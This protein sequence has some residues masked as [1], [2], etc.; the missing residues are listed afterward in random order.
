[1]LLYHLIW[2]F[3]MFYEYIIV[4]FLC[5]MS[6]LLFI[7]YVPGVYYCFNMVIIMMSIFL[8][9]MV[10]NVSRG[11]DER[12]YVPK[13][14]HMVKHHSYN[15]NQLPLT[16]CYV[17]GVVDFQSVCLHLWVVQYI[18]LTIILSRY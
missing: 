15:D 7:V 11:S 5:F 16:Y 9:S 4:H 10:V 2:I 14:V 12:K 13:I 18:E 6:V 17:V 3:C 8:S 1:M